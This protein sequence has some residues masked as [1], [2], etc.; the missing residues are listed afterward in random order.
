[1]AGDETPQPF[2][3]FCGNCNCGCPQVFLDREAP[4]DRRVRIT[5][6]FGQQ[7]RMSED[8][9]RDLVR[10]AKEGLLDLSAASAG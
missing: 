9:F 4:A 5:D 2:A 1:M 8:Q 7:I 6:D 10:Q 3:T